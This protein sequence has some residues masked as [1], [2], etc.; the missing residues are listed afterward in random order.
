M[1]IRPCIVTRP[2]WADPTEG[3]AVRYRSTRAHAT[4]ILRVRRFPH[5]LTSAPRFASGCWPRWPNR[6]SG[7][8]THARTRARYSRE[9]EITPQFGDSEYRTV[10]QK[11]REPFNLA[12][13]S[14]GVPKLN[15]AKQ[16]ASARSRKPM[17]SGLARPTISKAPI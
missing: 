9:P 14:S 17:K 4:A 6:H 8:L 11:S 12:S 2:L 16:G 7:N 13:R 15:T 3:L 1:L 10:K 5:Q